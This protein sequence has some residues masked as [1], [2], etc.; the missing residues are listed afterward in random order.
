MPDR[1]AVARRFYGSLRS[2]EADLGQHFCELTADPYDSRAM[3][4]TV[5]HSRWQPETDSNYSAMLSV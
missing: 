2:G 4:V 3:R 5:H 1:Y